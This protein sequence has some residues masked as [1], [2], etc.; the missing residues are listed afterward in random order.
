MERLPDIGFKSYD[1]F[2]PSQDRMPV[3]GFGN[4]IALPLQGAARASGNSLFIDETFSP[5]PDQWA[6]LSAIRPMAR[7]RV[8]HLIG[9]AS[10]SGKI[11][12]VRIPLVDED[13]E[14]W[15]APPSRR[16]PAPTIA[17]PLPSSITVVRADQ[18]YITRGELPA[19]LIACLIRLAAFQNPE[20][21]AA[22]AVRRPTHD[23][24]RIISCAELTS[25]HIALPRGC[26]DAV[27]SLLTSLGIAVSTED[28]RVAGAQISLSFVGELRME[29]ESAAAALLPHDTGILAAT[30]AFGKTVVAIQM[31]AERGLN[32]LIL[33]HRRLLMDQWIERLAT[34]SSLPREAIGVIGGGRRKPKGLIDVALI[35]SLVRK[36]EVDDLVGGYGHVI[37]D[38]CHHLSAVSF[39]LVARRAKA[40][41]V[42]GLSATVTRKDGHHPII[43][44]QCGPVRYCVDPRSEAAR[45]PFDHL[46][47]IR[48]TGFRLSNEAD[49]A[50]PAIQEIFA[51]LI[52]DESRNYL[53]F[54]DILRA[55]E[56]GR[57]PV[58]ITERTVHLE[59]LASRLERF[60]KHVIVLRG[61]QRQ[62][63]PRC[64]IKACND[65][66]G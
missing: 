31:I 6:F 59:A 2:F 65:R 22:Q 15:L 45:R 39:E 16:R 47:R 36:G 46:V 12:A 56:V 34:F 20:Y 48:E 28:R 37:V 58:V 43:A 24:P 25:H 11:L 64:R 1:R 26:F 55:L 61:G 13:E 7:S 18:I 49:T 30:T 40:R 3:G 44:M 52:T 32:T 53:I 54:D 9:A 38:E 51:A 62:A 17:G 60:V 33:V 63:A 29:Q 8:D 19:A 41:Y 21:Y 5:Y 10:A 50:P 57:S 27:G 4:L 66:T 42:L 14:P 23:K 35:Q